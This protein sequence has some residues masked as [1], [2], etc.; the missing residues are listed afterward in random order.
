MW[1]QELIMNVVVVVAVIC[2]GLWAWT[3]GYAKQVRWAVLQMVI[4]AEEYFSAGAGRLKYTEVMHRIYTELP[5]LVRTFMSEQ[6][7]GE[8]IEW[9]VQE[10]KYMLGDDKTIYRGEIILKKDQPSLMSILEGMT[11]QPPTE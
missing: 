11:V 3:A 4:H 5:Y 9:A 8:L 2:A 10:L 6:K 7:A 1:D